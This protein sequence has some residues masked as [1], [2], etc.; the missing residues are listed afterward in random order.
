MRLALLPITSLRVT[1][2]Y[3]NDDDRVDTIAHDIVHGHDT[4]EPY[5]P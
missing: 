1:S 4:P 2:K 3:G 5:L